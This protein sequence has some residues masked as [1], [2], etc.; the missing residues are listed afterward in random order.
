MRKFRKQPA[1]RYH[2]EAN[3]KMGCQAAAVVDR[4][5]RGV[6]AGHAHSD[7]VFSTQR[8]RG[9]GRYQCRVDAAA[10]PHQ[11]LAK[12]ALAHVIPRS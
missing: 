9:D 6:R 3:A 4:A 11:H 5:G 8:L 10:Q 12:P 1:D 2:L 7:Y